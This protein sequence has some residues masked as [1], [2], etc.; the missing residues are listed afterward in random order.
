LLDEVSTTPRWR[1]GLL[2]AD[3]QLPIF[4]RREAVRLISNRQSQ[5]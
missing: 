2:I 4:G 5:I 3:Y 1:V